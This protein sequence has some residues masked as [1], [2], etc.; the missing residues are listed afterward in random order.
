MT[1]EKSFDEIRTLILNYE[2]LNENIKNQL[3][4]FLLLA[5]FPLRAQ[6]LPTH[7]LPRQN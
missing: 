4:D 1:L 2:G 3:H 7:S 5:K 6:L